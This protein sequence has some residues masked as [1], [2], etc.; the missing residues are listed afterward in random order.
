MPE[1]DLE[2][3][4]LKEHID[5]R[6]EDHEHGGHGGHGG[7]AREA[8]PTWLKYLSLS[9]A[10]IAVLAAIASLKSG[11]NSNEAIFDRVEEKPERVELNLYVTGVEEEPVG[12]AAKEEERGPHE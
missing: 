12:Q 8:L 10:I 1:E 3:T 7:H 2:T 11:E 6:L 5:Q 4:E 9:T